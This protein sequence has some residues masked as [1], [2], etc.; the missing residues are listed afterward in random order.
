MK[1]FTTILF[2]IFLSFNSFSREILF[3]NAGTGGATGSNS[4]YSKEISNELEKNGFTIDLKMTNGNCA[5]AKNLWDRSTSPTIFIASTNSE[6]TTQKH[7][8]ACYIETNKQNFLYHL[9]IGVTSF[10][11]IGDKT[12]DDFIKEG[13]NH[14]VITMM[15]S[16]QE[17]F[18]QEISRAYRTKIKTLRTQ[19]FNDAMTMIKSKEVDFVFRVSIH[20]VPE[21]KDKCFWNHTEIDTKKIVPE[22]SHM[23]NVYNKFGEQKFLMAKGFTNE[24]FDMMRIHIR[25]VIRNNVEIKKQV[26]KRGQF[27]FDWDTKQDFDMIM[28]KF[29]AGY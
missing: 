20:N 29:F 7:N 8:L 18:I 3:I 4:V 10:C 19:S 26:E 21:L 11:S 15:D 27:V 5:L 17:N 13:S 14:V 2:C 16:A 23:S 9:N 22:L 24:E 12:W 1:F 28:D 6:G 25:N